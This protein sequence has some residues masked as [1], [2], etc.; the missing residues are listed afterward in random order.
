VSCSLTLQ[1]YQGHESRRLTREQRVRERETKRILHEE[2]LARLEAD[3]SRATSQDPHADLLDAKRISERQLQSQKEQ[4][5]RELEKLAAEAE[6]GSWIFDC[7]VCGLH[8]ENYDDGSHSIACD[9]CGV[10]QHSKCH[11]FTPKQAE[12]EDF[13]FVCQTCRRKEKEEKEQQLKS[14]V[15]T[16]SQQEVDAESR[17]DVAA[18]RASVLNGTSSVKLEES[19]LTGET[20]VKD[21]PF[22][23]PGPASPFAAPPRLAPPTNVGELKV[24]QQPWS[25]QQLP[26]PARPSSS[27]LSVNQLPLP[28]ST[29]LSQ[30]QQH[31][32][33]AL[34][35]AS[36]HALL[37]SPDSRPAQS[38]P[39]TA[40]MLA[41]PQQPPSN[42]L[43]TASVQPP[44]QHAT[45]GLP[46]LL[47]GFQ[48]PTKQSRPVSRSANAAAFST[49]QQSFNNSFNQRLE[50]SPQLHQSPKVD[51][52]P[53]Q[54]SLQSAATAGFSPVKSSP[55]PAPPSAT[56]ARQSG[57]GPGSPGINAPH[58]SPRSPR[59]A[60][61]LS[62]PPQMTTP[63]I[64][65][66]PVKMSPAPPPPSQQ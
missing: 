19:R 20:A 52:P 54:R 2:Q 11:G 30:H 21:D 59:V 23:G 8:G 60:V 61:V 36:G 3:S 37:L 64:Q 65:H 22:Q 13:K 27:G 18:S 53:P 16:V 32:Q 57:L 14:L 24:P 25:G 1:T 29:I 55:A 44:P 47:N 43:P 6:D 31:H 63:L 46:T 62:P 28:N 15:P 9:R 4:H 58:L 56:H 50:S 12:K 48:S 35:S 49:P 7:A 33:Q 40:G 41:T 10:W 66:S 17:H 34:E 26:P 5:Q 51:L 42:A 39:P 38:A 45:P